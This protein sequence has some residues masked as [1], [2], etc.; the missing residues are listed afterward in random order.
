MNMTTTQEK[1]S[2]LRIVGFILLVLGLVTGLVL[3]WRGLDG[4]RKP[5]I[6]TPVEQVVQPDVSDAVSSSTSNNECAGGVCGQATSS[7]AIS[8]ITI[9][10]KNLLCDATL[11]ICLTRPAADFLTAENPFSVTGTA[12]AFENQFSWEIRD[13]RERILEAGTAMTQAP[14]VG[15]AGLF[16]LR[17]FI[18]Q[19]P[20]T[21][22]GTLHV[23]EPSARDGSRTHEVILPLRFVKGTTQLKLTFPAGEAE[24]DCG[25]F[26]E[27]TLTV[28]HTSN[29]IE[30][31]IRALLDQDVQDRLAVR[32]SAIPTTTRLLSIKLEQGVLSLVFSREFAEGEGGM[33]RGPLS[34][35]MIERTAKQFKSVKS[36]EIKVEGQE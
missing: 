25:G 22:T 3:V 10:E 34:M 23:F 6:D 27:K 11:S 12:R 33:C 29:P 28:L 20:D 9:E 35:G 17:L 24:Q 36:V 18:L 5:K 2:T 31:T 32:S 4:W 16:D 21:T 13:G 26:T 7:V 14:D 15:L 8:P 1:S 19:V 30:A